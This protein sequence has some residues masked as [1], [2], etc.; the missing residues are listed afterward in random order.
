MPPSRRETALVAQGGFEARLLAGR[1]A[2]RCTASIPPPLSASRQ[3]A[4]LNFLAPGEA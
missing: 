4:D 1:R 2:S 3:A